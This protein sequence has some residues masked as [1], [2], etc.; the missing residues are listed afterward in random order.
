M[1]SIGVL[2]AV[3]GLFLLALAI[4]PEVSRRRP[5]LPPA[6]HYPQYRAYWLGVPLP[7]WKTT[8]QKHC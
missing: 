1:T 8:S 7:A 5:V 6:L 4:A 3:F 2:L